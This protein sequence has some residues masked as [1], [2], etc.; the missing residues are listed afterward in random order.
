MLVQ[1]QCKK[2]SSLTKYGNFI[3]G[4]TYYRLI[5]LNLGPLKY[6]YKHSICLCSIPN[7]CTVPQSSSRYLTASP[8]PLQESSGLCKKCSQPFM[9]LEALT[10]LNK[11]ISR[12]LQVSSWYVDPSSLSLCKPLRV[13]A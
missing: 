5:F 7:N 10:T 2:R 11:R 1:F 13:N 12:P 6:N 4:T 8:E 3:L 9:A